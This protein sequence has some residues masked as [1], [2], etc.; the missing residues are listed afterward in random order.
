MCSFLISGSREG[1]DLVSRIAIRC[2][3]GVAADCIELDADVPNR[4]LI[5]WRPSFGDKTIDQILCKKPRPPDTII[6]ELVRSRRSF[7]LNSSVL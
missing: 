6:F 7:F 5:A 1:R 4:L 2:K 3:T